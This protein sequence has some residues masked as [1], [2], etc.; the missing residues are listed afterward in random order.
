MQARASP[1]RQL[2][3]I[4]RKIRRGKNRRRLHQVGYT[5][6]KFLL[7]YTGQILENHPTSENESVREP[8]RGYDKRS[9]KGKEE[10]PEPVA[11]GRK[12]P[13][14]RSSTSGERLADEDPNATVIIS[15]SQEPFIPDVDSR[16]PRGRE[17]QYK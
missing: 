16:C 3:E 11:R 4:T 8:N 6:G 2:Q 15:S 5:L 1:C 10:I 12:R 17:P 7:G 9:E 13:L 14:L